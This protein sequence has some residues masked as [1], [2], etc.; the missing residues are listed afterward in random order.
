M[1]ITITGEAGSGKTT[2][3]KLLAKKLGYEH[4]S[5]GDF[6]GEIASEK[7]IS[8]HELGK[9]AEKDEEIDKILDKKQISLGKNKDD[10]I[11]DS[12]LGWYFIPDSIKIFL[13]V[14]FDEASKRIFNDKR[15]DE[16]ENTSLQKTKEFMKKRR[17][18]EKNRYLKYYGVDYYD[19]DNYDLL[20]DTTEIPAEKVVEKII[21][22]INDYKRK[23]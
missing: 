19:I 6:M 13:S 10:F 2:V 12:R 9:I 7:G 21:E 23:I 4:H 1:K 11:I 5:I 8:M 22:F 20:I 15:D 18:S 17:E 3:A 14:D 16:K